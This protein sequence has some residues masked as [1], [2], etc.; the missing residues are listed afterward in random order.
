[1][2]RNERAT[3]VEV[4]TAVQFIKSLGWF[5]IELSNQQQISII[6]DEKG[7]KKPPII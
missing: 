5:K 6:Q 3:R 4:F 7:F 1:M 2:V